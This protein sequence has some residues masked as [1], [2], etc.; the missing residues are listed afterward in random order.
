MT[1]LYRNIDLVQVN[2]KAGVQDYFLPKNVEWAKVMVDKLVICAPGSVGN[3]SP[4]DGVTNVMTYTD[5]LAADLYFDLYTADS[6]QICHGLHAISLLN[7]N[8]YVMEINAQL[9]REL[10]MLH[11]GVMPTQDSCL[12]LYV[13]SKGEEK[14]DI[15]PSKKNVTLHF[16]LGASQKMT[17]REVINTYV[18]A[19]GEKVRGVTFYSAYS[20]PLYI[21]LRDHQLTYFVNSVHSEL[22]RP[23]LFGI[24]GAPDTQLQPFRLDSVDVDFDYSF[25]QNAT[26]SDEDVVMTIEY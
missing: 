12:L 3:V 4:I 21:T 22:M 25:I 9:S 15:E 17:L 24:G 11:F 5:L 20:A 14:I 1:Q 26:A 19:S 13:F 16:H 8:N 6:K 2:V 10:S 7:N 23:D 18:H